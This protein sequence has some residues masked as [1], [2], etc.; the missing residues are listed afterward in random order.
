MT[1][2]EQIKI[3]NDRKFTKACNA[4]FLKRELTMPLTIMEKQQLKECIDLLVEEC[5]TLSEMINKIK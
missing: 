4:V 2:K 1:T 3:L 5:D